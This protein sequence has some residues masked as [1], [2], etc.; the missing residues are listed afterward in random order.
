M[1]DQQLRAVLKG[2]IIPIWMLGSVFYS[3]FK[4]G[5]GGS[6]YVVDDYGFISLP[7]HGQTFF[8]LMT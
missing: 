4:H 8:S 1:I 3:Y 2:R 6:L 5:V 7:D